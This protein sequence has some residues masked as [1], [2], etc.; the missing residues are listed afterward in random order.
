[1][2]DIT[3]VAV[4][5]AGTMGSGIAAQVANAGVEVLLLDVVPKGANDRNQL[6][7]G[8]IAK[9]AKTRPAPLM[10]AGNAAL[11]QAGNLEDDLDKLAS[12]DWIIEVVMEDL[13]IKHALYRKIEAHRHPAAVVSS[14]TSTLPLQQ[15]VQGMPEDVRRHFLITHFFNPPR[16]MRLLEIVIG[17]DTDKEQVA[18]VL[19]FADRRLGKNIVHCHDTPGFIANRIGTYWIHCAVTRALAAGIGVEAAD[20][21]LGRPAGIPKTGVFGLIDLVGVDLMP[22]LFKSFDATLDDNDAF[23]ELGDMPALI[24]R[25]IDAGY[26]GRKGKGGFYRLNDTGDKG[27]QRRRPVV[28][29]PPG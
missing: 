27:L 10:K 26:T 23:R 14:N 8:A 16:Y 13:D 7:A 29:S 9:M 22:H 25:M 11:I 28:H 21:V 18:P 2:A 6:A 12:C 4:L 1:M 24:P 20:A 17:A 19:D 15:L 3:R 5:G